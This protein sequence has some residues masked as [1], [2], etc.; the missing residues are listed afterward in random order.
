MIRHPMKWDE[1][2]AKKIIEQL[3]K[4][5]ME[6]SYAAKRRVFFDHRNQPQI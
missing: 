6:G 5:G 4:R 1:P 2:V 3:G